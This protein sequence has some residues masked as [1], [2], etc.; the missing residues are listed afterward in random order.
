[1]LIAATCR[2]ALGLPATRQS[3]ALGLIKP[4]ALSPPF[5]APQTAPGS[6]TTLTGVLR[7][8]A[9]VVFHLLGYTRRQVRRRV[10][11]VLTFA[12]LC[13]LLLHQ[14]FLLLIFDPFP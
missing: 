3:L 6:L 11:R 4:F 2:A 5:P 12:L 1:M 7:V 10:V 14:L 13:K 8:N 9:S